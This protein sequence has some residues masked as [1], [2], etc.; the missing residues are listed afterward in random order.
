MS[1]NYFALYII[2]FAFLR[3][4]IL[5]FALAHIMNSQNGIIEQ[6][7]KNHG[8]G[9]IMFRKLVSIEPPRLPQLVLRELCQ[10]ANEVIIHTDIPA[11]N[12]EIIRRVD[13]ADAVLVS[14]SSKIDREVLENCPNIA[15]I[16]MCCSLY[17][18]ESANVDIRAADSMGIAVSGAL[19]YGDEGVAEYAVSELARLLHGFGGGPMWKDQ[20]VELTGIEVGILGMGTTGQIIAKALHFFGAHISYFSRTRK[21]ELESEKGYIYL[22][23]DELLRKAEILC[24]CLNKNVILLG[25]R[26]FELFGSG[27]ILMNTSIGPSFEAPALKE[28][29]EKGGNYALSDSNAGLGNDAALLAMNGAIS[30]GADNTAGMTKQAQHR[31][32]QKV[33][34]NIEAFLGANPGSFA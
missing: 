13:D 6:V 29:L 3:N 5:T 21:P 17:S 23:L 18:P 25:K 12:A 34:K 28:W 33:V 10:Y 19:D 11:N 22:P 14:Y 31:L 1:I 30:A 7:A 27:K 4:A 24:T 15:Y 32:G 26:E 9:Y 2:D 20:P 8:G 16:G